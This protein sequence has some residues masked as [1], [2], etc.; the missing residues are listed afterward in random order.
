[1]SNAKISGQQATVWFTTI[2]HVCRLDIWTKISYNN[3]FYDDT[4]DIDYKKA[5]LKIFVFSDARHINQYSKTLS[6]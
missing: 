1:M 2:S 3:L 5:D 6:I 4:N